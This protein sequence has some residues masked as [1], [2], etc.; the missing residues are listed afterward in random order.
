MRGDGT[1]GFRTGLRCFVV[2]TAGDESL[3][4]YL[5]LGIG[6]PI[7]SEKD[8][9]CGLLVL[10][11]TW[12]LVE[13][14][15]KQYAALPVRSLPPVQTAYP[16]RSKVFDDPSEG[17]ATIE[18]VYAALRVLG[19]S[20]EELLDAYHWREEFLELNGFNGRPGS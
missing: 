15:E 17:L 4:G 10:D 2:A 1:T 5:R 8:A 13:R 18:A 11:G 7:L 20:T 19:R 12:R 6:G 9:A 14:M 3:D 16:R